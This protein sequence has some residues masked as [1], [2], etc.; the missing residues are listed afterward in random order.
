M[1]RRGFNLGYAFINFTTTMAPRMLYYALQKSGWTVYGSKK[2]KR[3]QGC[4][5]AAAA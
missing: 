1:G 2:K 5:A 4:V 3:P